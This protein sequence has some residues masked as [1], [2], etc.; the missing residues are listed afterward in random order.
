VKENTT[1]RVNQ[2]SDGL[3]F[4]ATQDY[5]DAQDYI[6]LYDKKSKTPEDNSTILTLQEK[7]GIS[8]ND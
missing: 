6:Y 8:K 5:Q 2:I 3:T 7:Y 1:V 4:D